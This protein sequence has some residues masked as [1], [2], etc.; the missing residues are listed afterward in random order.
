MGARAYTARLVRTSRKCLRGA[1]ASA[2]VASCDC[3]P[4][5]GLGTEHRDLGMRPAARRGDGLHGVERVRRG[6]GVPPRSLPK[7]VR[8]PTRL[9]P[10]PDVPL[11]SLG[12]RE[13]RPARGEPLHREQ[14]LRRGPDVH[15]RSLRQRLHDGGRVPPPTRAV[16]RGMD[17][18]ARCVSVDRPRDDA[19]VGPD[20]GADDAGLDAADAARSDAPGCG[21]VLRDPGAIPWRASRSPS[22]APAR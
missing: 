22:A 14:R 12:R 21:G 17:R 9:S 18:R 3:T 6:A 4:V 15:R 1:F 13:L 7:R 11:G 8:Q 10:R 16:R 5:A 19:G 20:V 2:R